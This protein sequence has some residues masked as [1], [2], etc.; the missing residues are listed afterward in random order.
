MKETIKSI[1]LTEAN[2]YFIY[3]GLKDDVIRWIGSGQLPRVHDAVTGYHSA[4]SRYGIK[5][6]KVEMML[7]PMTKK[8]ALEREQQLI[9][10]MGTQ[11]VNKNNNPYKGIPARESLGLPVTLEDRAAAGLK[12]G[13]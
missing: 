7:M 5:F 11:L 10:F 4:S 2:Q 12:V 1:T 6:D 3:Y 9:E 8:D 13:N